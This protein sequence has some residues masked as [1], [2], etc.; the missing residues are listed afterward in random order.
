MGGNRDRLYSNSIW[1]FPKIEYE[2]K[3]M[4]KGKAMVLGLT[5]SRKGLTRSRRLNLKTRKKTKTEK[6]KKKIDKKLS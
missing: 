4:V 5:R 6:T 3:W 1:V 2:I